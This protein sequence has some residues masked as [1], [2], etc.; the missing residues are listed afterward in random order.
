M[1]YVN[2]KEAS[3]ILCVS[4]SKL[5]KMTHKNEIRYFKVGSKNL[6]DVSDLEEY[7]KQR[8]VKPVREVQLKVIPGQLSK[9][10]GKT[11]FE[12]DRA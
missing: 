3:R 8:E 1:P 2:F 10:I 11:K 9:G 6:F 5:Y 12:Y 7:I 4:T